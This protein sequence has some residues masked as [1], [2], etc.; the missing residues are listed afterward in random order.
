MSILLKLSKNCRGRNTSKF[1]L[2]GNHHPDTKTRQREHK[3]RKLQTNITDEHRCKNPQQNFSK[4]TSATHQKARTPWSS[5][6]SSSNARILQYMQINV[7]PHINMCKDDIHMIISTDAE[8]ASDK[9]QHPFMIKT[10]Q[11]MLIEGTYL[12]LIKAFMISLQKTLFSMAKNWKHS[13]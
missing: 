10:L 9:I 12:N 5:W 3:K 4:Q 8:T 6:V 7:T 2:Q 13:L 11:R 1:I